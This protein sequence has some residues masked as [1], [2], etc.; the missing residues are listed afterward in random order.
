MGRFCRLSNRNSSCNGRKSEKAE[1]YAIL[2][3]TRKR[4]TRS[5]HLW[6]IWGRLSLESRLRQSKAPTAIR[7]SLHA[8]ENDRF[9]SAHRKAR[10]CGVDQFNCRGI[11]AIFDFDSIRKGEARVAG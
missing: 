6:M 2:A 8:Y 3:C 11:Q 5:S 10:R 1:L 4:K 7:N 9:N